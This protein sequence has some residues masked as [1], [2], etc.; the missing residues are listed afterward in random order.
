VKDRDAGLNLNRDVL[1]LAGLSSLPGIAHAFETRQGSLRDTLG[2]PVARLRQVHGATVLRLPADPRLWDPF[3]EPEPADRPAGDA[4]IAAIPGVTLAVAVAD[5]LPVLIADLEH[6]AV[7]AVHCGW[8]GLAAE[9]L[10]ATM[11]RMS[12]ELGTRPADCYAGM[13]PGIGA[14]CYEVGREVIDA[15]AAVGMAEVAL[16]PSGRR[17]SGKRRPPGGTGIYCNLPAVAAAQARQCGIPEQRIFSMDQCT[18][19]NSE[20]LW[21]YRMEGSAAGRMLAGIALTR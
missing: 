20:R 5:C 1:Q 14:C 19:C 18:Y 10:A 21:S 9:V 2:L 12:D 6:R 4:I 13:G 15:F 17:E 8:R 3:L 7:A 11:H 16:Q